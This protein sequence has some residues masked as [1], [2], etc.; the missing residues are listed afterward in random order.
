MWK[1]CRAFTASQI[2]MRNTCIALSDHKF[3]LIII[4]ELNSYSA[5]CS[6][7]LVLYNNCINT[8]S[9]RN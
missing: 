6:S 5:Q 9:T 8:K 3:P 1:L 2:I 4:M 7:T